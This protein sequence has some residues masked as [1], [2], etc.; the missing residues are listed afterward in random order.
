[1]GFFCVEVV[2]GELMFGALPVKT[3]PTDW[4]R[5]ESA[6]AENP[7]LEG[8]IALRNSLTSLWT[9]VKPKYRNEL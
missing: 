5:T 3:L 1:M 6:R 2:S 7:E 8:V 9:A 4:A